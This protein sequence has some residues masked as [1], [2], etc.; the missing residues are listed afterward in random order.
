MLPLKNYMTYQRNLQLA[1]RCG[2]RPKEILGLTDIR[3]LS[4]EENFLFIRIDD[5]MNTS[6][7]KFNIGDIKFP[8]YQEYNKICV[9]TCMKEYSKLT[10]NLRGN[11]T[12]LHYHN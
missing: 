2:Q 12:S 7:K 4:F 8:R 1:I 10:A 9:F 11:I 5:I 6:N 3:N